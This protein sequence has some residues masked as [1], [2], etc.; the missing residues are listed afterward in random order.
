MENMSKF[1]PIPSGLRSRHQRTLQIEAY[2]DFP[3]VLL[4]SVDYKNT[5]AAGFPDRQVVEQQ[6]R[7]NSHEVE[8]K[9]YDMWSYQGSSYDWGENDILKLTASS[10]GQIL[11][12]QR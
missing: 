7:F 8:D 9:R 10:R 2:D 11:W 4:T 6:H 3:N 12:V 1:P 5:G